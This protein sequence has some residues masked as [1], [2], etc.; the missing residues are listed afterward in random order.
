MPVAFVPFVP[1]S[2]PSP[3]AEELGQ[4]LTDAITQFRQQYPDTSGLDVRQA[5]RIALGRVG[6]AGG[7]T[8]ALLALAVAVVVALGAALSLAGGRGG[9]TNP[10]LVLSLL[11]V[12]VVAA[13]VIVSRR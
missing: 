12:L 9:G 13:I 8:P 3:R 4:R 6:G 7:R 1:P 10:W 5:V 11:G 2:L